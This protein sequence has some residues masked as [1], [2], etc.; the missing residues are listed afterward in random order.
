MLELGVKIAGDA[1]HEV[2]CGE[3]VD[4]ALLNGHANR[5][6]RVRL[7]MYAERAPHVGQHRH[8]KRI[9]TEKDTLSSAHR[10]SNVIAASSATKPQF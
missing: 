2:E 4:K 10:L 9:A 3:V 5:D 8:E 7:L 6:G 1:V